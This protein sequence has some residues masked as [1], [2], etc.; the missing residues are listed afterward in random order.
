MKNPKKLA[1]RLV[2]AIAL[3]VLVTACGS[4]VTFV[5]QDMTEYPPRPSDAVVEIHDND[6]MKPH[7]VIGTLTASPGDEGLLQR[8]LHL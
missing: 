2:P 5:R 1:V 6:V 3:A 8:Q 4:G 7:V